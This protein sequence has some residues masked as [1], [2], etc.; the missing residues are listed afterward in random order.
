M[1]FIP[2]M[3]L[4]GLLGCASATH[5]SGTDVVASSDAAVVTSDSLVRF[6]FPRD[7]ARDIPWTA[8]RLHGVAPSVV[9]YWTI[10]WLEFNSA[11]TGKEPDGIDVIVNAPGD[12]LGEHGDLAATVRRGRVHVETTCASCGAS[13]ASFAQLGGVR[14]FVDDNRVI[15]EVRGAAVRRLF[16][17]GMPRAVHFF[18]QWR[19]D[20]EAERVVPIQKGQTLHTVP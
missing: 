11:A 18:A 6:Y 15:F 14:A 7:S 19:E 3:A 8:G 5:L 2:L 13:V 16:P 10:S 20:A 17:R 12:T 9:A 1:R 4:A